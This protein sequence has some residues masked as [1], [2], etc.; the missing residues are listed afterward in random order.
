NGDRDSKV[1]KQVTDV[2]GNMLSN[3]PLTPSLITSAL[4]LNDSCIS[5]RDLSRHVMGRVKDLNSIPNLRTLLTKEG[6]SD[7]KS[8]YL[9]GMWVMIELDNEATKLKVLQ[10]IGV[11][12]W[13]YVFQ[14][15][16]HDFVSDERVVSVDIEGVP[17]N[18]WSRATF[19]KIG[20]KWGEPMDIEEN[21]V[22]S[23]SRKRLCI[24][25]K[26]ADII[27]E[28]FKVIF[29]GKVYM[30]RAK[31]LFTWTPI[32]LDHK[33]SEYISDDESLHGAKNK[34]VGSQH[35]EDDLVD[36]S[37]VKG[38]SETFFGDKHPSPN[39]SVCNSS[40][41]VVEQQSEDPFCI[42]DVLNK[43]PKGIAQDSDSSLSHP[44][45]FTSGVSQQDNDHRG[46][47]LNT[48]TNNVNSPLVHT[49]VMNNSQKVHENVTSN[50]ESVFNYSH[51]AH[52]GGS[53][54]EVLDDMIR[55]RQ[56]MGY[57]IEGCMKDIEHI[58][59]TQGVDAAG[60]SGGILCV[61]EAT[62]F[63]KDYAT[64]SD[65]FIAIYGTWI[66]NN[67]K[68][69]IVVIYAPR[70]LYH[71][72]VLWDYISS[73]IARWNG[74]TI[75]M[76]DF[77]EVRSIDERFGSMFNQS[78]SR[79]FNHFITSA[80]CLDPH[81]SDHRPILLRE[82]HTDYGPIPFRSYHSLFKWD[83]FDVMVEQALNSFSHS[84]TNG[85]IRF[86]K[87][88]KDLKKIIRSWIKDKKLQQ[89]GAINFIKK[90]LIDIDKNLDSG[91]VSDEILLKI[92][93]LTRQLHD[94]N[95]MEA[96]DYVQKLKIKWAIEGDKNSKFF[97]GVINK[98]LWNC[99]ENKS[100]GPYGYTFEFFR[101][102]WRF[103]GSVFCSAVE[104]FFESGSFPEGS[105]S[106]FIAL[107]PKVTDAKFVTDFR[108]I[109]LIGCVYKVVTK[110]L[111]NRLAT[112]PFR[113]L[114]VMVEDSM[115]LKLAWADMVQKLC[116]WLSKWKVKT[117]SIG[118]RLTFLK[119]VLGD[120]PLYNMSIYKVPKG[121]LKEME[122]IRCNFFNG[123]DPAERKITWVS[124]DKVLASK[125][126]DGLRVLSFLAL[127]RAL[128][129]IVSG[130]VIIL[131]SG[132]ILGFLI[133]HFVSGSVTL[134]ASK[135]RWICDLNGDGV[136]R[137]K[138]VRTIL[139]DIF[140]PS[141]A[142]ATRW[143]K[144]IP[145]KINVFA[146]RARLDRLPTIRSS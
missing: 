121:V 68:V 34:S 138:E 9:G 30:A 97:H 27:L 99:S 45:G 140:L 106:S 71:K 47:D 35:G 137:V 118:G 36:D 67:S 40:E 24:K 124:W 62:I 18:V 23:F 135:D 74:E 95:Q 55:V 111:A 59:G 70:S 56:S 104:C 102:Y 132:M 96:R 31:E 79:L 146:W 113:Y 128:L 92:I 134:S 101:R 93:E 21:L 52:N 131:G 50:E 85:L 90:D 136:F 28:K 126:N 75:V 117:L 144:Y 10:H 46:V 20:K 7:V 53:I 91:N 73:L 133:S 12:S 98:K 4:V 112:N 88:L 6:F 5:V 114:G 127:N 120:S 57:D 3:V 32:F 86:K 61:W 8:T 15:A 119:S 115:S 123:V 25:T 107:I 51:N 17:L 48:E 116:S 77:N 83:V 69:L 105:N 44:P 100:P 19:L 26:Q 141:A 89:S 81:L 87:K 14:A 54:L 78:S 80:L 143:A 82:I 33:E 65:N 110:I 84:D 22:S 66:S 2:K 11:N 125:Q 49:K 145:I 139:D 129:L 38:V 43:K 72:R 29:K 58:I 108:P 41:K 94:I 1:K 60:N 16:I 103:I 37:D 109:S 76:G 39:N 142:D 13:F 63:K 42:Y 130:T 122:A 64:V